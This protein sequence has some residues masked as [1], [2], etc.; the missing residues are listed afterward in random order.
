MST[1]NQ[2]DLTGHNHSM[3]QKA[4]DNFFALAKS[5]GYNVRVSNSHEDRI[6]HYDCTITKDGKSYKVEIKS[7]KGFSIK[8]KGRFTDSFFLVEFVGVSGHDGWLYGQADIVAFEEPNGFYI[9]SRKRLEEVAERLCKGP[10]VE[11]KVDMLYNRYGRKDRQDEV[12]A[13]LVS[14]LSV[15]KSL[16][17]WKK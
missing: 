15:E 12:S 2:Y 11:K 9:V 4:E 5:K 14:D 10:F 16:V 7:K 13:I 17:F 1:R 8:H 6:G 3:G